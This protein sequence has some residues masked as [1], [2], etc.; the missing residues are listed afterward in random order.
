MISK[1]ILIGQSQLV[2]IHWIDTIC[3]SSPFLHHVDFYQSLFTSIN[4]QAHEGLLSALIERLSS[5]LNEDLESND[6]K[7]KILTFSKVF[8]PK[9][10]QDK[11]TTNEAGEIEEEE[12]EISQIDQASFLFILNNKLIMKKGWKKKTLSV[13]VKI[14]SFQESNKENILKPIT[15]T[16][17]LTASLR[18]VASVWSDA[19]WMRNATTSV[20]KSVK[21]F[22]CLLLDHASKEDVLHSSILSIIFTGHILLIFIFCFCW[23]LYLCHIFLVIVSWF[24][25][26]LLLPYTFYN[27]L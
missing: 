2:A 14:L 16:S 15:S 17:L 25:F 9:N 1:L 20:S 7:E 12:G 21:V 19:K 3:C 13:V 8:L 18:K 24:S 4:F 27:F 5:I 6:S 10:I 23:I 26:S 11:R 22:I